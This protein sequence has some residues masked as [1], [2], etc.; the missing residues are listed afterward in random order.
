MFRAS[1][2]AWGLLELVLVIREG[3]HGEDSRLDGRTRQFVFFSVIAAVITAIVLAQLP[4][5]RLAPATLFSFVGA[6]ILAAGVAV[7]AWAVLTLGRYFRLTL[8]VTPDQPVITSGPYRFIRH[9][10]YAAMLLSVL[11]LGLGLGSLLSVLVALTMPVPALLRRINLEE[12][13]LRRTLGQAYEN[14]CGGT[15]RLVPGVW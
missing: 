14:Y 2:A 15:R 4:I 10:A 8:T 3:N 13:A 6:V 1:F 5:L 12:Q 11:G 7:R 9:P